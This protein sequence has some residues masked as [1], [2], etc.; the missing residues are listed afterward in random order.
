VP[1][2][3]HGRGSEFDRGV[4]F[5]DAIYGFAI[6]LLITAVDVP[7]A[8]AWHSVHALLRSGVGNQIVGFA[9]ER[10]RGSTPTRRRSLQPPVDT[11]RPRPARSLCGPTQVTTSVTRMRSGLSEAE[12]LFE[13]SRTPPIRSGIATL[14]SSLL[15]CPNCFHERPTFSEPSPV[16]GLFLSGLEGEHRWCRRWSR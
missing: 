14:S 8:K 6:T 7:S 9:R 11:G 15:R 1:L 10:P 4:S 16:R 13:A 2:S 12:W 3:S 5:F